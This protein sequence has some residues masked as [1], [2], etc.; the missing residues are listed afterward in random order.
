MTERRDASTSD[1]SR[2]S[3][4]RRR[5]V[6]VGAGALAALAAAPALAAEPL[7]EDAHAGH[8]GHGKGKYFEAK[9]AKAHPK[10]VT[11]TRECIAKGQTCLS[12]CFE[13]F[14]QGD[15]TMADCA[16][17]VQQMLDVCQAFASLASFDSKH[18]RAFAPVCIQVCEDCEQECRKHEEHQPECKA[19]ADACAALVTEARK[20]GA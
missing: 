18:L 9:A 3:S 16:F 1:P 2:E 15:T 8:E 11:A 10:L 7:G 6:L 17:A 4:L 12:H 5:D 20:L 13:T 14:R 19:C